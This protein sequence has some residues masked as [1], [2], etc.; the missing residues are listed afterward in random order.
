MHASWHLCTHE[1]PRTARLV[2]GCVMQLT[3]NG[4]NVISQITVA[5]I[6]LQMLYYHGHTPV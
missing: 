3:L 4:L 1:M 2:S 5:H 6:H